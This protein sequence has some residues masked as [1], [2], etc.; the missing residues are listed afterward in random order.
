MV[1]T[2]GTLDM[3]PRFRCCDPIWPCGKLDNGKP[4]Y[5]YTEELCFWKVCFCIAISIYPNC[6]STKS[7]A[8]AAASVFLE[9]KHQRILQPFITNFIQFSIMGPRYIHH[10]GGGWCESM[11]D[12]LD[13]SHTVWSWISLIRHDGQLTAISWKETSYKQTLFEWK[14][15]LMVSGNWTRHFSKIWKILIIQ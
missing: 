14:I 4:T 6:T 8:T 1:S 9:A 12:C 11:D 13:R 3:P 5:R 2:S 10:E 7:P 15:E